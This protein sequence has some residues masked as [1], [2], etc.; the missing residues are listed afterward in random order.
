MCNNNNILYHYNK[1]EILYHYNKSENSRILSPAHLLT[2]TNPPAH[3]FSDVEVKLIST[4][5]FAKTRVILSLLPLGENKD[6]PN[7]KLA[8]PY[9][10]QPPSP[11][12]QPL[13]TL[14]AKEKVLPNMETKM[15]PTLRFTNNTFMGVLRLL[16]LNTTK[17]NKKFNTNPNIPIKARAVATKS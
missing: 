17:I 12:I 10:T 2:T 7:R 9:Q 8:N 15:S 3:V 14:D 16:L 13:R 6:L 1:S 11:Q 5:I 4:L